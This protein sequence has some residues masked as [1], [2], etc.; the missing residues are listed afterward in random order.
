MALLAQLQQHLPVIDL[1]DDQRHLFLFQCTSDNICPSYEYE[2]GAGQAF[3][4]QVNSRIGTATTPPET[5]DV[6]VL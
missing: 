3:V 4:W 2:S 5:A 1:G 6:I